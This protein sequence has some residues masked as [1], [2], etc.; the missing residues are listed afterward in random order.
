[1]EHA[2]SWRCP[3]NN[4]THIPTTELFY[5]AAFFCLSFLNLIKKTV[6]FNPSVTW[7]FILSSVGD[8]SLRRLSVPCMVSPVVSKE[9][10]GLCNDVTHIGLWPT[11]HCMMCDQIHNNIFWMIFIG[12]AFLINE[13]LNCIVVRFIFKRFLYFRKQSAWW[14]RQDVVKKI[15]E[16]VWRQWRVRHWAVRRINS[17]KEEVC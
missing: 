15:S 7:Q 6:T 16:R 14:G 10:I 8:M 5:Q 1:M 12:M 4:L 11:K 13:S 17:Q 2:S 9:H 3:V